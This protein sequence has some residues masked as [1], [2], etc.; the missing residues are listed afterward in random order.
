MKNSI[1]FIFLF[2]FFGAAMAQPLNKSTANS[3]KKLGDELWEI[4]DYYNALDQYMESYK[5][6]RDDEVQYRI[7]ACNYNI[8]SYKKA[9]TRYKSV[10]KK[11]KEGKYEADRINY[12]RSLKIIGE[13]D[14]AIEQYQLV[15]SGEDDIDKQVIIQNEITGTETA[16]EALETLG[17]TVER[18]ENNK[19]NSKQSEYSPVYDT[20][21]QSMYYASFA[22]NEA[23]VLDGSNEDD[24][25]MKIYKACLLYTSPSP[26]D[27]T[28]SR[29]PSSA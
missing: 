23:I 3:M 17:L 7:A 15:L 28:R 9:A 18:L 22:K 16:N 4:G 20:D 10:F 29:M 13:Y 26:R 8:R 1:I 12:A 6:E 21:G 25:T 2:F 5:E 24:I 19:I 11:D 14:D 27:R